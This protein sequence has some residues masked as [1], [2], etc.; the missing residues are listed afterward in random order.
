[1]V[2]TLWPGLTGMRDGAST[3]VSLHVRPIVLWRD[4]KVTCECSYASSVWTLRLMAGHAPARERAYVGVSPMLR[5]ALLWRETVEKMTGPVTARQLARIAPDR[6][7]VPAERRAVMRGGRRH[8]DANAANLDVTALLAEVGHLREE[9]ELLR[10]AAL[11]FGALAE[12]LSLRVKSTTSG[13]G[14]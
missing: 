3:S 5:T 4:D 12:R 10:N 9:N 6:R 1:M 8:R 7:N 14:P 13:H 11:T 2:W